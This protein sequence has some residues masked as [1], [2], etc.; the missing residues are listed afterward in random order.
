MHNTPEGRTLFF[1]EDVEEKSVRE[2]LVKM[3]ALYEKGPSEWITL[4]VCS[5][6]G[7]V[8]AAYFFY[9]YVTE[10]LKP[11]LQTVV[12]GYASSMSPIIFLAGS[13]RIIGSYASLFFHQIGR[14]YEKPVRFVKDELRMMASDTERDEEIYAEIVERR[15]GGKMSKKEVLKLIASD[16]RILPEEA[17]KMGFAHE[18]LEKYTGL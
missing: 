16:N 17:L 12:L 2:L 1:M 6:G 8:G 13:C 18:I 7:K 11:N 9:E 4:Y 15:T 14:A 5:P 10:V 3:V